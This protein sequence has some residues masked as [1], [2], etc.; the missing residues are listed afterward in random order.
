EA[1]RARAGGAIGEVVF[2]EDMARY[3]L[4]LHLGTGTQIEKVSLDPEPDSRFNPEYDETLAQELAEHEPGVVWVAKQER[5]PE[6]RRRIEALG[7]RAH[8]L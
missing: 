2:V 7:W 4:H 1:I 8:P 6:L 3:G 5:W